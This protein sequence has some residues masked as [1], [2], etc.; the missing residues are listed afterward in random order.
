MTL[1]RVYSC[2]GQALLFFCEMSSGDNTALSSRI[3]VRV[4][5][6]TSG[7]HEHT[8]IANYLHL[9]YARGMDRHKHPITVLSGFLGAGKTTLLNHI[10]RSRKGKRVAVVVNDMGGINID[11]EL[12]RNEV[13]ELS[14]T[15]EKLV[16]MR[17]YRPAIGILILLQSFAMIHHRFD[18]LIGM[19]GQ[20]A[21]S[22]SSDD[23]AHE[24]G[25]KDENGGCHRCLAYANVASGIPSSIPPLPR[26]SRAGKIIDFDFLRPAIVS[27]VGIS[28]RA[29]PTSL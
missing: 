7:S 18:H 26:F 23:I 16:V 6:I 13:A 27:H 17:F 20:R 9:G 1:L 11:A 22:F 4:L 3:K 5:P 8:L 21:Y 14:R 24:H 25:T 15:D 19:D 2:E 12:V 28:A 10:L 29:P